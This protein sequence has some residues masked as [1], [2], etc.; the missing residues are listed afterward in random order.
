MGVAEKAI[1]SRQP[2]RPSTRIPDEF[3]KIGET[4]EGGVDL[5]ADHLAETSRQ[6]CVRGRDWPTFF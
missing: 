4:G 2:Q 6:A 1:T 5:D 3:S